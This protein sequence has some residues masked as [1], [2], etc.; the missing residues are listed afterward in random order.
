MYPALRLLDESYTD[1]RRY[2]LEFIQTESPAS[3]ARISSLEARLATFQER[4]AALEAQLSDAHREISESQTG[5]S[6]SRLPLSQANSTG[7]NNKVPENDT[8]LQPSIAKTV[9]SD[10]AS[11]DD[12]DSD[13]SENFASDPLVTPV[14]P[15]GDYVDELGMNF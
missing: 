2:L 5:V 3:A 14:R 4:V 12:E 15:V 6:S 11:V 9:Q 7:T 13:M 8:T 10:V 1:L